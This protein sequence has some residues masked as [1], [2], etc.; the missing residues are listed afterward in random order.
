MFE[1]CKAGLKYMP[2]KMTSRLQ[3]LWPVSDVESRIRRAALRW[4]RAAQ[5]TCA[6]RQQRVDL[7]PSLCRIL[8]KFHLFLWE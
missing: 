8:P 6:D 2:P 7:V 5:E 3:D 4:K 1:R